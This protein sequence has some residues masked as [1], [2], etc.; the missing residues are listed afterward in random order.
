M[1]QRS[2]YKKRSYRKT[3]RRC[4]IAL[5]IF[6]FALLGLRIGLYYHQHPSYDLDSIPEYSGEPSVMIVHL[7][8]S[9]RATVRLL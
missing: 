2:Y 8:P 5:V 6:A 7:R 9:G 4:L 3:F 1:K